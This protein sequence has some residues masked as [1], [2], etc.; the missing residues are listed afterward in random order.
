MT[1]TLNQS[2]QP[3]MNPPEGWKVGMPGENGFYVPDTGAEQSVVPLEAQRIYD[4]VGDYHDTIQAAYGEDISTLGAEADAWVAAADIATEVE[5]NPT[6][7]LLESQHDLLAAVEAHSAT[8]KATTSYTAEQHNAINDL[9][10]TSVGNIIHDMTRERRTLWNSTSD[11]QDRAKL[12]SDMSELRE[13]SDMLANDEARFD[14]AGIDSAADAYKDGG[15]NVTL[16]KQ[17]QQ[18][19]KANAYYAKYVTEIMNHVS[20]PEETK[21]VADNNSPENQEEKQLSHSERLFQTQNEEMKRIYNDPGE[22]HTEL[23]SMRS[24]FITKQLATMRKTYESNPTAI[25]EKNLKLYQTE[26]QNFSLLFEFAEKWEVEKMNDPNTADFAT[27]MAEKHSFADAEL[28]NALDEAGG[29][30]PAGNPIGEAFGKVDRAWRA[31]WSAQNYSLNK[32]IT[33]RAG[34]AAIER[35]R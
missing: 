16:Q 13:Y 5:K 26:S 33:K 2:N 30:L 23:V 3:G 12:Q 24:D 10:E 18:D 29:R 35:L 4:T 1:E 22:L 34:L 21:T 28:S 7:P 9:D 32:R 17:S 20:V 11:E 6:A 27:Y 14:V 19:T 8:F 25:N 15:E 31:G